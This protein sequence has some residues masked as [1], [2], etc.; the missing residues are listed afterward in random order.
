MVSIERVKEKVI[1]LL[2]SI[3]QEVRREM[4]LGDLELVGEESLPIEV[5]TLD[6]ILW[7]TKAGGE[8]GN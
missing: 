3:D 4:D 8:Q 1:D 6:G 7:C 5:Q 2:S